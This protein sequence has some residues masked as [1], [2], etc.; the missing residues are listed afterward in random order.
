MILS[1]IILAQIAE[2]V[3][4]ERTPAMIEAEKALERARIKE[5]KTKRFLYDLNAHIRR[6][7][8]KVRTGRP[9]Y[10]VKKIKGDPFKKLKMNIKARE[11]QKEREKLVKP[12]KGLLL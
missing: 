3:K 4:I 9:L 2:C 11:L 7:Q 10:K 8:K 1:I 6:L 12:T 5:Q